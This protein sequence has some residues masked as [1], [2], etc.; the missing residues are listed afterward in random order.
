MANQQVR[1]QVKILGNKT[2]FRYPVRRVVEAAQ[3]DLSKVIPGLVLEIQE[4]KTEEEIF[5]YTEVLVA[6]GLVIDEKLVYDL[7][8]PNKE[9]VIDWL[10]EAIL[11]KAGKHSL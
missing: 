8:I 5:R 7:W 2:R 4:L 9:Q 10:K 3:A 1:L 11:H 6:P